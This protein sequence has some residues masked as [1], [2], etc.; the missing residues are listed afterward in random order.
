MQTKIS[1]V[2]ITLEE[3]PI[4]NMYKELLVGKTPPALAF[5]LREQFLKNNADYETLKKYSFV[6]TARG[7][8]QKRMIFKR[9]V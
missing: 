2:R 5:K 7:R 9:K 4:K 6:L 1:Q 3:K 8:Q